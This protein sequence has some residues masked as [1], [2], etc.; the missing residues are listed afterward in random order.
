M[1]HHRSGRSGFR[2]CE[3]ALCLT[4]ALAVRNS[5]ELQLLS[6][7]LEVVAWADGI[8]QGVAGDR[9]LDGYV[10]CDGELVARQ[11]NSGG[12]LEARDQARDA[13]KVQSAPGVRPVSRERGS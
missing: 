6:V 9:A 8:V 11:H 7:E 5:L 2:R 12:L 13:P 3:G 1:S 10:G 4:R